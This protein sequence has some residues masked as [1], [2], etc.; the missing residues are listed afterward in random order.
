[1]GFLESLWRAVEPHVIEALVA[2][3]TAA[4][5]LVVAWLRAR[6]QRLVVD[7]ATREA[8][9]RGY[10]EGLEGAEKRA[11]AAKLAKERMGPL[12]RPGDDTLETLIDRSLPQARA[13]VAPPS[14]T[15][16]SGDDE[17]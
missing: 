15:F 3:I 4:T 2:I 10:R 16:T 12:T 17:S 9:A 7:Q 1:M 13:S 6:R 14:G 5:P 11:H 8:E